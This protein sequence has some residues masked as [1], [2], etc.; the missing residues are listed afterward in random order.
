MAQ[1]VA[2]L[3]IMKK[4]PRHHL[5]RCLVAVV[6]L[7]VVVVMVEAVIEVVLRGCHRLPLA[8]GFLLPLPHH[9]MPVDFLQ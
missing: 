1:V 4:G 2:L 6:A 8:G 3:Q 7:V 5:L 9:H